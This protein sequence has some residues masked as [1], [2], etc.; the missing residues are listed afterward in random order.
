MT[1]LLMH[2]KKIQGQKAID[3][4]VLNSDPEKTKRRQKKMSE[5]KKPAKTAVRKPATSTTKVPAKTPK[6]ASPAMQR[7]TPTAPQTPIYAA[8]APQAPVNNAPESII[9]QNVLEGPLYISDIGME[10]GGLEVRDLTWEDPSVVKRSQDLRRAIQVGQLTRITQADWDHIM[11]VRA[12]EARAE[13]QRISNRRTRN[14][15]ADGR[16]IEAE[17]LNLNKAD[18]GRAAQDQVSTAG[19]ANGK[20][21]GP[22][23]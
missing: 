5:I 13:T 8:P 2:Q 17:V 11:N 18:G 22:R 15:R 12:A 6:Q 21:A 16:V 10:F 7:E 9:V 20:K 4:E 23:P 3:T 19:Y 1:V 14:V